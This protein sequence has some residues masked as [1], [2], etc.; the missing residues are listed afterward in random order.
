[1]SRIESASV[2][3]TAPGRNYVLLRV[4]TS[5][6]V[7]GWGDATL[8]GRELAVASYLR[9]HVAPLLAGLDATRIEDT[10]QYLYRGSYWRGGPV[11]MTA[12][13]AVDMALWDVQGR[14][15]GVPLY[16]LLGGASRNGC[17]AYGHAT[18]ESV[19]DLIASVRQHLADGYRAIRVQSAIPGMRDVYGVPRGGAAY[20]PAVRGARP[21]EATWDTG[22]YLRFIPAMFE[23]VRDAVGPDVPLLH[24]AHHR[25]SP[26][27]ASQ[28]GRSLEPYGL[29]WLEDVTPVEDQAAFRQIRSSTT[30]PLAVGEIFSS[31]WDCK[32]LIQ[33]RLIDFVRASVT[34]AGGISH[35]RKLLAFAELYG[36]RSGMHGATDISP[37]GIAANLHLGL[38]I[39]NFGIQEHMPHPPVTSDVF[40]TAYTFDDGYLRP[41]EAPGLGVEV[42]LDAM[43]RF[44]YQTAYL[45]VNRLV[46]GTVHDW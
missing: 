15:L 22:A 46:D 23:Q 9:D 26:R 30:V 34:H 1:M 38:A 18:G 41:G 3:V 7:V 40:T 8:N 32:T 33:E 42:D 35:M 36:V 27:E 28:L 11:A 2:H 29:F 44:E 31:V 20:E 13:A 19:E 39:N 25:L 12:I 16:Q 4:E 17:L 43:D 10:W 24:D 37:V 5:D 14:T 45:P 21:T 6:G